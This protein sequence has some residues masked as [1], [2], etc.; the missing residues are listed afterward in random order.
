MVF[1]K[2]LHQA[3]QTYTLSSYFL[4]PLLLVSEEVCTVDQFTPTSLPLVRKDRQFG[5]YVLLQVIYLL[6][7]WSLAR[8]YS[9]LYNL[10]LWAAWTIDAVEQG[11]RFRVRRVQCDDDRTRCGALSCDRALLPDDIQHNPYYQGVF[12]QLLL[13][14]LLA[15]GWRRVNWAHFFRFEGG[16]FQD[17][18]FVGHRTLLQPLDGYLSRSGLSSTADHRRTHSALWPYYS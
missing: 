6:Y 2:H 4:G 5:S 13:A 16:P 15:E 12:A 18:N 1:R 9:G 10:M 8:L 14:Q 17:H 11:I 3:G 7:I